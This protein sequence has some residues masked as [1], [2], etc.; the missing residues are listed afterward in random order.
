MDTL[1]A[2]QGAKRVYLDT[3]CFI[4]FLEQHTVFIDVIFVK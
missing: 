2:L 3:N 1:K 4:Y